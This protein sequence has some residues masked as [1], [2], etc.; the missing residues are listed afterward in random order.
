[1]TEKA[2]HG[3]YPMDWKGPIWVSKQEKVYWRK[4][5]SGVQKEAWLNRRAAPYAYRLSGEVPEAFVD[6]KGKI[7]DFEANSYPD[8][9]RKRQ[10]DQALRFGAALAAQKDGQ[11]YA[12]K[13]AEA[14]AQASAT[15][16]ILPISEEDAVEMVRLPDDWESYLIIAE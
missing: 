11:W 9:E 3:N 2:T 5:A 16:S 15:L 6:W 7:I 10:I 12:F 1:M 4:I 13:W 14:G 8:E